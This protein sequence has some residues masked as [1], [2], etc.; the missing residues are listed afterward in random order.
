MACCLAIKKKAKVV[1]IVTEPDNFD[2]FD[3]GEG[4]RKMIIQYTDSLVV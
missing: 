2:D 4:K 1:T 3:E